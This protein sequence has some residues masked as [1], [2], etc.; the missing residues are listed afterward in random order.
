M[1]SST[2]VHPGA[3][4]RLPAGWD[5]TGTALVRPDGSSLP[6]GPTR[7]ATIVLLGDS[8]TNNNAP[9]A[10]AT[11][12][13]AQSEGFFN[14]GN[15][16]AGN[17]FSVVRCTG[18]GGNTIQQMIDR[19]GT[20]VAPYPSKYLHIHG[21]HNDLNVELASAETVISRLQTLI[22]MAQQDGRIPIVSTIFAATISSWSA[23]DSRKRLR[24]NDWIKNLGAKNNYIHVWDGFSATVDPASVQ[25]APRSAWCYDSP[26]VHPNNVGAYYAG[27][28]LAALLRSL[29]PDYPSFGGYEDFTNTGADA[30][31]LLDNVTMQGTGGTAGTGITWSGTAS[32]P[33]GWSIT[34]TGSATANAQVVA[35]TDPDTGLELCKAIE[36]TVTA[37]ANGET[38]LIRSSDVPAR[39]ES[40]AAY[41]A[42]CSMSMPT[43]GAACDRLSFAIDTDPGGGG[44]SWWGTST[45][46]RIAYPEAISA[47]RAETRERV[48]SGTPATGQFRVQIGFNG[49]S[50]G[51]VVR[52]WMPRVRKV[53]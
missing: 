32:P 28:K 39:Y 24:V 29:E 26:G 1:G 6:V 16:L 27:K 23:A 13:G 19:Y 17:R 15:A 38:I 52:V 36:I 21:G 11:F 33:S 51:T 46:T 53:M 34:R 43:P 4:N 22:S 37:S 41:M 25:T 3:S 42:E 14:W 40:G 18:I 5:S 45:N 47:F 9:P 31:N 35:I 12:T 2:T 48:S 7:R 30:S 50:A 8:I 20:D 49:S 10:S 44:A